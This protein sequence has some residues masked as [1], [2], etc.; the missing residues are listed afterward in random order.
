MLKRLR[1]WSLVLGVALQGCIVLP[2][3]PPPPT[4]VSSFDEEDDYDAENSDTAYDDEDYGPVPRATPMPTPDVRRVEPPPAAR[5]ITAQKVL[6]S[7]GKPVM[8]PNETIKLLAEVRLS[9]GQIN[10]NVFWSS[11]DDRIAKVNPTTGEVTALSEGRVTV[12]AA[13]ALETSIK[14]LAE[15]TIVKDKTQLASRTEAPPPPELPRP[16]EPPTLV[17]S[18]VGGVQAESI[19]VPSAG[20]GSFAGGANERRVIGPLFLQQGIHEVRITHA[21]DALE[22]GVFQATIYTGDG[23]LG[24]NFYTDVGAFDVSFAYMVYNQGWYY[25]AVESAA[26]AWSISKK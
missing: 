18:S 5:E 16:D 6:V 22:R 21:G 23:L 7:P 13:Y 9:D 15:L 14:G 17:G 24:E 26:G 3:V 10:G 11:S 25:L 20:Q 19:L 1:P 2:M 8:E 12:V 4:Y